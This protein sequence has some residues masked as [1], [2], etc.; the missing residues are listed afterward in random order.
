MDGVKVAIL[1][2]ISMA[3]GIP[4][5]LWLILGATGSLGDFAETGTYEIIKYALIGVTCIFYFV[6]SP[7]LIWPRILNRDDGRDDSL[8]GGGEG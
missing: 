6:L 8:T 4:M 7:F 1:V 5:F 2:L 3:A